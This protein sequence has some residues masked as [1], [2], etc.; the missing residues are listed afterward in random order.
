MSSLFLMLVSPS[1]TAGAYFAVK[2]SATWNHNFLVAGESLVE[3]PNRVLRWDETECVL[4]IVSP[5]KQNLS[6]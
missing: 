6:T 5:G 2:S 1:N 3:D 4:M